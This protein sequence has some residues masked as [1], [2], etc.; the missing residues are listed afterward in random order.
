MLL[1]STEVSPIQP[2]V[3]PYSSFP[4]NFVILVVFA[5]LVVLTVL[6]VLIVLIVLVVLVVRVVRCFR[7]VFRKFSSRFLELPVEDRVVKSRS[8]NEP[9]CDVIIEFTSLH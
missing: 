5:V 2:C 7:R 1:L 6:V 4:T 8:S 9:T 3:L